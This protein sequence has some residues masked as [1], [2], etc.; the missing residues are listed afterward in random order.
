MID[1]EF[2]S[3]ESS[4][5][6]YIVKNCKAG[7]LWIIEFIRGVPILGHLPNCTWKNHKDSIQEFLVTILFGTATFWMTAIL[8]KVFISNHDIGYSSLLIRTV[9]DGQLFIF[10]V[11]MLG[12]ILLAS[13]EDPTN[14]KPFPGRTSHL[15]FI[16]LIGAL[17]SGFYTFSLASREPQVSDLLDRQFLF[18]MSLGIA[19]LVVAMRYLT[20]V[21]R[22]STASFDAESGFKKPVEEFSREF[23]ERHPVSDDAIASNSPADDI[24]SRFNERGGSE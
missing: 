13:A 20:T 6:A 19:S 14:Y 24:I 21:Y 7:F 18:R 3:N 5:R 8:L 1:A 22:K 17:A 16:V 4:S 12:P 10:S 2:H 15:V 23:E 11:G 9:S